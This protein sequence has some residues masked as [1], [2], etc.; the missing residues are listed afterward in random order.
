[1]LFQG[2]GVAV[3]TPFK[4]DFTI[5]F[6]A[7][8]RIVHHCIDGQVDYL[9]V[10]GTTGES[11][12]LSRE[13]NDE[14]VRHIVKLAAGRIPVVVG[15]GGNDTAKLIKSLQHADF[16]GISGI[17]T[18]A[19]YY[20]KPTQPG[21]IAHYKAIAAQSPVPVILYNIPGRTGINMTAETTL[22]LACEKNIVAI[23]E[24]S[25]NLAQMMAI[26]KGRPADFAVISG[27]DALT[28]PLIAVGGDGIISVAANAFP[29]QMSTMV[30]AALANNFAEARAVH[31][32]MLPLFDAQIA[33]GNPA[34]IKA[35]LNILGL[36][37]NVL[38]L[39][40]VPVSQKIYER[41]T[42]IISNCLSP[43]GQVN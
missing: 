31:Y 8:S 17:L 29:Q 6:E 41:L 13:E 28:L 18:V 1:M 16:S 30:R 12:T 5:D 37:E 9:V 22:S 40:L 2:T 38:R 26:I 39:P 24:A 33:D 35:A 10:M 14:V 20:N 21:L 42:F 11:V 32:Q 25:G 15:M 4:K 3:I 34:G 43:F 19:P 7:L 23:K 36:T 27:D